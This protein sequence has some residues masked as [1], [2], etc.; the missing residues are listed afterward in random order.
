MLAK[1]QNRNASGIAWGTT[2][3][4]GALNLSIALIVSWLF[5]IVLDVQL[6]NLGLET[7]GLWS[8]LL[9][10]LGWLLQGVAAFLLPA[11]QRQRYWFTL[12]QLMAV[13]VLALLPFAIIAWFWPTA[14]LWFLGI[15]VLCSSSIMGLLHRLHTKKL[16]LRKVWT[17]LWFVHLMSTATLVY[18]CIQHY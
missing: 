7:F 12:T 2:I 4:E 11:E 15:G 3:A 9:V 18:L 6:K 10:G 5:G 13:G 8:L 1:T 14:G 17:W 16:H